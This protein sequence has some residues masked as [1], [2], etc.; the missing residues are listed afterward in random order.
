MIQEE[1]IYDLI[2][3]SAKTRFDYSAFE[4]TFWDPDEEPLSSIESDITDRILWLILQ[5]LAMGEVPNIIALK[6]KNEIM[7]AGLFIE[8]ISPIEK[9]ITENTTNWKKEIS[10][11]NLATDMLNSNFASVAQVYDV[12]SR[13]LAR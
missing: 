7:M 9:I 5:Y 6:I 1:Q 8:D 13:T 11:L 3:N 12:V 4:K 2:T 10:V